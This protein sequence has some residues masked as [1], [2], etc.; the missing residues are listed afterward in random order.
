MSIV[1]EGDDIQVYLKDIK[2]EKK[3]FNNFV[4]QNPASS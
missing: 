1:G 4:P 2:G 3:L